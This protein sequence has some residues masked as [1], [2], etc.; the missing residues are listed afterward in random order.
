MPKGRWFW[1]GFLGGLWGFLERKKG[2]AQFLYSFRTSVDSFW[3]VG[4]KRGWWKGR[5]GGDVWVFVA[6]LMV[7]NSVYEVS[8]GSVSSGVMRKGLGVLRGEGWVDRVEG[9]G[10]ESEKHL[11]EPEA[12]L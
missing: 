3:K 4:V 6:A 11:E 5:S 8:P 9:R 1:G 7:M 12:E 2:R 10:R